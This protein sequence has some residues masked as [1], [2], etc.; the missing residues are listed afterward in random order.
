[1][2]LAAETWPRALGLFSA[3]ADRARAL[4]GRVAVI[5]GASRGLGAGMAA[6]FASAGIH[7][8]LCAR[9]RPDLVATTRP[10]VH[11]GVVEP[12]EAPLTAAVDVTDFDQ[13][14]GFADAVVDRFGRIDL[15]VNN[16]GLLATIGPLAEAD[17]GE[18]ARVV[19]ANLTGVLF[20]STLFSAH[21]RSRPGPGVLVN[22]SSGASGHP[23][24][25]W[26]AYCATK[27]G[28][29]M[30]TEVVALEE[31]DHGLSAYSVAPGLVDTD[32][33]AAIRATAEDRF[34]DVARFRRAKDL[35]AFNSAPWVAERLLELAFGGPPPEAVCLRV[36]TE[37]TR[38]PAG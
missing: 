4:S 36:P 13:L 27:A 3:P 12:A 18:T 14:A 11:D 34:P 1:V 37:V 24:Q 23:Y 15:W 16:A 9:H 21:V 38:A 5:T 10:R 28:V 7:L 35:N 29:D 2:S 30:A 33:Q 19:A 6:H 31:R 32:M 25:G 20:G 22:V 17:P 8:G 26:A